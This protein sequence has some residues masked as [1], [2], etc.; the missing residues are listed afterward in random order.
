[1]S[2]PGLPG[3]GSGGGPASGPADSPRPNNVYD[4]NFNQAVGVLSVQL[5]RLNTEGGYVE[6]YLDSIRLK[7]WGTTKIKDI[8]TISESVGLLM[9]DL[10]PLDTSG[11]TDPR[12]VN[13]IT[14]YFRKISAALSYGEDISTNLIK[15]FGDTGTLQ[16]IQVVD[17][18]NPY[19]IPIS[20]KRT[21]LLGYFKN[22]THALKPGISNYEKSV[23]L[24]STFLQDWRDA[25]VKWDDFVRAYG[26][27]RDKAVAFSNDSMHFVFLDLDA[28]LTDVSG[29]IMPVIAKGQ[30]LDKQAIMDKLAGISRDIVQTRTATAAAASA[31]AQTAQAMTPAGSA[32][33]RAGG[34]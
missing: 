7:I 32:V 10:P 2:S 23:G 8:Q 15:L 25:K 18:R 1:M 24:L 27:A 4:H 21:G 28:M 19:E 30:R 31:A 11:F 14:G 33:L 5:E 29:L 9:S 6:S 16:S 22:W 20:A 34:P 12:V 17:N 3:I 13:E 26:E